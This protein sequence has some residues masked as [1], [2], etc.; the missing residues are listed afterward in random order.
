MSDSSIMNK[1]NYRS[2][3]AGILVGV[4]MAT[5]VNV[6]TTGNKPQVIVNMPK[7][8]VPLESLAPLP[9]GT[10]IVSEERAVLWW[11]VYKCAMDNGWKSYASYD[12]NQAVHAVYPTK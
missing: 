8:A 1:F 5:L 12:A 7:D 6:L 2:F 9:E 4:F 11:T 10:K 3:I